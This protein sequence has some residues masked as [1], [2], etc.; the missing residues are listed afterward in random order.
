LRFAL[1]GPF[2]V[3]KGES[4]L[5]I[6]HGRQELILAALILARA[7]VVS[8]DR[9][10]ELIWGDQPPSKPAQ[11][12]RSYVSHLR[13][14]LEPDR[15]VGAR[16]G[17]LVTTSPGYLLDVPTASVDVFDFERRSARADRLLAAGHHDAALAETSAALDLWRSEDLTD[18]PLV[19]FSGEQDR[20]LE[21]RHHTVAVGF[22]AMLRAGRHLEAVPDLRQL[23]R[24]DPLRE[25]PR[26]QLMLA[27][28]RAGR[29]AEAVDVYQ[30][31]YQATVEETGLDPS[32]ALRRLEAQ[33]LTNDP[34]LDWDGAGGAGDPYPGE[35]IVPGDQVGPW[36]TVG[37]GHEAAL[38]L[39]A[40]SP[41]N[42]EL[43]AVT[44]EPGIGKTHLIE[45]AA[46][47]ATERGVLAAW[48]HG[49]IGG[50]AAPL[51]PWRAAL[52]IIIDHLDDDHLDTFE[53]ARSAHLGHL[54]PELATRLGIEST[55][56][57]DPLALQDAIVQFIRHV[58]KEQPLL[59]CFDD[60]HRADPVSVWLLVR[61]LP[62]VRGLPFAAVVSW[63]DTDPVPD[64]LRAA[65]VALA[66]AGP[67]HRIHL[68]GFGPDAVAELWAEM[69]GRAGDPVEV[70]ELHTRTAGNPLFV[71]E[72]LRSRG[73]GLGPGT[74]GSGIGPSRS[75]P[76]D[77]IGDVIEARLAE[78]PDGCEEVL[79]IC[80]LSPG[81]ATPDLLGQVL[82]HGTDD[83]V[84]QI[85]C[86]LAAGLIVETSRPGPSL[87]VRHTVIADDLIDRLSEAR[88]ARLHTLI[89]ETLA[90]QESP[91]GTQAHH[92]LRGLARDPKGVA[93]AAL[94]AAAESSALHDH[95]GAIDLVERGLSALERDDDDLLRA[96]LMILL[97]EEHKH[98]EH[99]NQSH[100]AAL[101]GFALAERHH[102]LDLMVAAT[103][104]YCGIGMDDVHYGVEWLGYWNPPGP[105][106]GM[107]DACLAEL[108]PNRQR[109]V[110][111]VARAEELFGDH[112][113]L[114]DLTA[115]M[116]EA[117]AIARQIGIRSCSRR[118]CAMTSW[119]ASATCR[120]IS[121]ASCSRRG[122]PP[123]VPPSAPSGSWWATG[124]ASSCAS[125]STT[126][127]V[128]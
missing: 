39:H 90:R 89:A 21:L 106:L 82:G 33:I 27:L 60:L 1:L 103:M 76:T 10:I 48:G 73:E 17:L 112:F 24:R 95:S 74:G 128:R 83:V 32:P 12:L 109:V 102:D 37:R 80:A 70:A 13:R 113:D 46:R 61:L 75:A 108:G 62:V 14:V 93:R 3:L 44:G 59:L 19:S 116:D 65:L 68:T 29:S 100:A 77:T 18:S 28:H 34:R 66:R 81:S 64:D 6:A 38:V 11:T 36:C 20:L 40:I 51:A 115:T 69:K 7:K 30:A 54:V 121:A 55:E 110:C 85:D 120:S 123:P 107:L 47:S 63:R 4:Q 117:V 98:Q 50:Q 16:S 71:T 122:W 41:P 5:E 101:Q 87:K 53:P 52:R 92:F 35:L 104:A 15:R 23:V 97:A 8:V 119:S 111:L 118:P 94:E 99:Y 86:L 67:D 25:R 2:K 105:A 84:D 9:L 91:A 79:T 43:V 96:R 22:D 88:K 58:V 42:G 31:G 72:I 124:R 78:L 56:T 127:M 126:S 45:L 49:H 114:D 125:T 57:R 26:A